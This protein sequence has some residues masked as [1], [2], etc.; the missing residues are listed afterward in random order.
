M[1]LPQYS[2]VF[3]R[4]AKRVSYKG[5]L[6]AQFSL[7]AAFEVTHI[8]KRIYYVFDMAHYGRLRVGDAFIGLVTTRR[9]LPR[10]WGLC[11]PSGSVL[12]LSTLHTV[13]KVGDCTAAYCAWFSCLPL[14][15]SRYIQYPSCT[16]PLFSVFSIF[17]ICNNVNDMH[18]VIH[19]RKHF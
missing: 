2:H 1:I 5:A 19:G 16:V 9:R 12:F 18:N 6:T 3:L 13:S 7:V 10:R 14:A 11:E 15:P 8:Y 17:A 4:P